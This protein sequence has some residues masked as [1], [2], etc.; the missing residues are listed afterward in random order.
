[1]ASAGSSMRPSAEAGAS[2]GGSTMLRSP[3]GLAGQVGMASYRGRGGA[4]VPASS[5]K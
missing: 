4:V 2:D 3:G 5:P 1:M